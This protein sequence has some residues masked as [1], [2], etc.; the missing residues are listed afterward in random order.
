MLQNLLH[1]LFSDNAAVA[2]QDPATTAIRIGLLLGCV[3]L[4]YAWRLWVLR[5]QSNH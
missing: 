5:E 3:S 4:V 2:V 1:S